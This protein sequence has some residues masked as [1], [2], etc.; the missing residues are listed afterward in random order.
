MSTTLPFPRGRFPLTAPPFLAQ[1]DYD[2]RVPVTQVVPQP[3]GLEYGAF[4]PG[5]VAAATSS[6][7]PS[8]TD[9]PKGGGRRRDRNHVPRPLNCFFL[10][11]S[12][13]LAKRKSFL[14][15]IEQDHRQLNR[16]ASSEWRKLPQEVKQRFK[17]AA[18]KAKVEHAMKYPEY[19]FMPK[20]RGDRRRR[21]TRRNEPEVLL[22]NEEAAR[23]VSQGITG[24]AL[25]RGL[26][27]YDR[28]VHAA[29]QRPISRATSPHPFSETIPSTLSSITPPSPTV[30]V[31]SSPHS[32]MQPTSAL[33]ELGALQGTLSG[34]SHHVRGATLPQHAPVLEDMLA[35]P[36]VHTRDLYSLHFDYFFQSDSTTSVPQPRGLSNQ[37]SQT[38]HD[39]MQESTVWSYHSTFPIGETQGTD[40][41]LAYPF[42]QTDSG[43]VEPAHMAIPANTPANYWNMAALPQDLFPSPDFTNSLNFALLDTSDTSGGAST[44]PGD[45]QG[46]FLPVMESTYHWP[47]FPSDPALFNLGATDGLNLDSTISVD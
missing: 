14:V 21:K 4:I 5:T 38:D 18:H 31:Y 3:C 41:L 15:G 11:K 47:A 37:F 36:E 24:D 34:C 17:D 1:S 16:M 22:R 2:I 43:W 10:F 20:P 27:N 40:P 8:A 28:R 30:D 35:T 39:T 9:S 46:L 6:S 32:A 29:H 23:L 26:A 25:L 45:S 12:D 19:R 33:P 13:W 7:P 44:V 42:F